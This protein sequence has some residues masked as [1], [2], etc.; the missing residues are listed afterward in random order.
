LENNALMERIF[1]SLTGEWTLEIGYASFTQA[2][3]VMNNM[4]TFYSMA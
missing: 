4:A 3:G 2:E 1:K